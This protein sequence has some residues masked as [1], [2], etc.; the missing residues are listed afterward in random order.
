M[1]N[2]YKIHRTPRLPIRPLIMDDVAHWQLFMSDYESVKLF[3]TFVT[4]APNSA[5][6]WIEKSMER[7]VN[8]TF[9][10]M[11]LIDTETN[12]FVGQCGLLT[13]EVEGKPEIEIGYSLMP[14]STGKGYATEAAQY[15]KQLGF[16][17]YNIPS[18]I[19]II[20]VDNIASQKVAERN[21]ML[22]GTITNYFGID[23]Y[24]YRAHNTIK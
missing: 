7:Y 14:N 5:Q 6:L 20:H 13:K 15:F 24:V 21:G 17:Q 10:L 18:L 8:N 3:P 19:S 2:Y 1:E 9:G 16:E 23:A 11:A 22:R 4:E 12:A